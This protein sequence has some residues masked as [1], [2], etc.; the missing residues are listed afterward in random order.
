MPTYAPEDQG[1]IIV[2]FLMR[3]EIARSVL[4]VLTKGVMEEMVRAGNIVDLMELTFG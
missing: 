1:K 2:I 3:M 4:T